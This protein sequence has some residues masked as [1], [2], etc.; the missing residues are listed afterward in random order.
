MVDFSGRDACLF[1]CSLG[2]NGSGDLFQRLLTNIKIERYE[3]VFILFILHLFCTG[4]FRPAA[5]S[6]EIGFT[7]FSR[8][9]S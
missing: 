8:K 2:N 3:K 6:L 4:N 5:S 1:V 7:I 9:L